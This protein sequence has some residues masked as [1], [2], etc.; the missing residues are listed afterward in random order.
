MSTMFPFENV[1]TATSCCVAVVPIV[2]L[3]PGLG[4]TAIDTR[5]EGVIVTDDAAVCPIASVATRVAVAALVP[6]GVPLTTHPVFVI[7]VG[8]DPPQ[9][10]V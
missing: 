6:V 8:N 10:Q 3:P 9:A 7:P 5:D 2:R 4:V 1:P